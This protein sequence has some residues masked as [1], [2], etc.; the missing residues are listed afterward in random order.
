MSRRARIP[1]T[2]RSRRCDA[3][4]GVV[5]F[6]QSRWRLAAPIWLWP[7]NAPNKL[8]ISIVLARLVCVACAHRYRHAGVP[9]E[10][11]ERIEETC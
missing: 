4:G 11:L 9:A 7:E 1:S 8:I 6:G 5:A 3:C 10:A 2:L